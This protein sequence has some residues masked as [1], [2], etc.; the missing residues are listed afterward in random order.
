VQLIEVP[1]GFTVEGDR[2][3]VAQKGTPAVRPVEPVTN[4]LEQITR[5]NVMRTNIQRL[6]P[7]REMKRTMVVKLDKKEVSVKV[8]E[9]TPRDGWLSI[10]AR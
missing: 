7:D 1:M 9:I 2:I 6:L 4:R 5:A 3:L 8:N 10:T